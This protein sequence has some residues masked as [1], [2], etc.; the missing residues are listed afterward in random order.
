MSFIT[1]ILLAVALAMDAFAVS[2]ASGIAIKDLR[3]K[4]S[5]II[6]SWFG[7]FQAIMP[8]LGWLSGVK[9]Q[10]FIAEIDHWI[11]FSLL[12]LIGCKMIYEA[13]RIEEVENRSDPMGITVLF[14]LSIATSI[15]AF[16]AGVSFALLNTGVITPI[17]I[18]GIITFIMSFIGVWIGDR[19][20]NFFEK[21]M[22]VAAGVV[23]IGIGIKVLI[24]HIMS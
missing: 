4:H 5:I 24:S 2:I 1:I 20:T 15:D 23:L 14:S 6:A 13:F 9:L 11:V 18:I 22:E 10:R 12:F 8:L 3:I 19:G 21:K 17:I 7:T 16:A